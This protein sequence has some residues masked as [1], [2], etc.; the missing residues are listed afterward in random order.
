MKI[1]KA[2]AGQTEPTMRDFSPRLRTT[3]SPAG[4]TILI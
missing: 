3:G 1:D 4:M 2:E